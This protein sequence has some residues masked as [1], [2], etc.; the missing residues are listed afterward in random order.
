MNDRIDDDPTLR[1]RLRAAGVR[2]LTFS[3]REGD[4]YLVPSGSLHEFMNATPCLSVAWNIMPHPANCSVAMD[5]AE[6]S[7]REAETELGFNTDRSKS[8]I[9]HAPPKPMRKRHNMYVVKTGL[10]RGIPRLQTKKAPTAKAAAKA[11]ARVGAK[12]EKAAAKTAAR[13]DL[14][15]PLSKCFSFLRPEKD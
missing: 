3:I 13:K 2:Y 4:A 10:G 15:L 11:T 14:R 9:E 5:M 7:A 12:A 6:A 1:T 8:A